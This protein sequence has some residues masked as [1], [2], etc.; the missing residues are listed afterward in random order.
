ML[1]EIDPP[2]IYSR[3]V[4]WFCFAAATVVYVWLI[5]RSWIGADQVI[6]LDLGERFALTGHLDPMGKSM[7]G[8]GIIPGSLLQILIG[9]PLMFWQD[10]R[11]P[12]ILIALCN[13]LACII[14]LRTAQSAL[15]AS[16][17]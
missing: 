12:L 11:A 15:P 3:R 14:F 13:I 1:Q 16:V 4:I 9:V 17:A 5:S 2:A 7:S 10:Y 6:L 8:G